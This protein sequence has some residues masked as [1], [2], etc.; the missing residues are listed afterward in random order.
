MRSLQQSPPIDS[1]SYAAYAAA[2]EVALDMERISI[3]DP[4][5]I[6]SFLK[7]HTSGSNPYTTCCTQ[8]WN[9]CC[10]ATFAPIH[11]VTPPGDDGDG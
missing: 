5:E 3:K 11:P 6:A 9:N 4:D 7:Y 8:C 10:N 1:M 2:R